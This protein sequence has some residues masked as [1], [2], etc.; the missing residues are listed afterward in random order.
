VQLHANVCTSQQAHAST[1]VMTTTTHT[2]Q[3]TT[4][5]NFCASLTDPSMRL[6]CNTPCPRVP[7]RG[8]ARF[9]GHNRNN[10][11]AAVGQQ[12]QP[13]HH[14]C[15]KLAVGKP[16]LGPAQVLVH[17]SQCP[18][19]GDA[20]VFWLAHSISDLSP[21]P[22]LL[23]THSFH[24]GDKGGTGPGL[25]Q[26]MGGN[27][28]GNGDGIWGGRRPGGMESSSWGSSP[29]GGEDIPSALGRRWRRQRRGR[30]GRQ[31]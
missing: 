6:A 22:S 29:P 30:Q 24:I 27:S 17:D 4:P 16:R 19:G 9:S 8:L 2:P 25:A 20:G 21:S 3:R 26:H 28:S 23:D 14:A 11:P 1:Q 12:R 5:I 18:A 7:C 31:E 10:G 13:S 15:K